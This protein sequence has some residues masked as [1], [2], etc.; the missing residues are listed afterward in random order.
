MARTGIT[1]GLREELEIF[2]ATPISCLE[3]VQIALTLA[4]CVQKTFTMDIRNITCSRA[5]SEMLAKI[6]RHVTFF[7][8]KLKKKC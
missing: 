3:N 8:P 2:E 1:G 7:T 5:F 4:K 6:R